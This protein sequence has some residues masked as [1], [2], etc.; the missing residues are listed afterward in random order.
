MEERVMPYGEPVPTGTVEN[1][2]G[3]GYS[4]SDCE[5]DFTDGKF[6]SQLPHIHDSLELYF[7]L[8]G[9]VSFLVGDR[10]Y[11]LQKGDVVLSR[12]HELHLCVYNSPCVHR[13]LCGWVDI[14][15]SG[16]PSVLSGREDFFPVVHLRGED[17]ERYLACA[18]DL[19]RFG[20]DGRYATEALACLTEM[21]V[22]LRK[23]TGKERAENYPD[24][25]RP[26]LDYCNERFC[27][28]SGVE[29]ICS[30]FFVSRSSLDRIFRRNLRIGPKEYLVSRKMA[31]AKRLLTEGKTVEDTAFLCGFGDAS[32]FIAVFK[33]RFLVTPKTFQRRS[34]LLREREGEVGRPL[35]LP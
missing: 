7:H 29:E 12:R 14:P 13:H 1:T 34:G 23:N 6:P 5:C 33:K 4:M 31:Y 11:P 8:S 18:K 3:W 22:L 27:E 20:G 24:D 15:G 26:I 30:H 16:L 21:F 28:I 19:A 9:D 25:F 32:H 17:E 10:V 35:P 2:T